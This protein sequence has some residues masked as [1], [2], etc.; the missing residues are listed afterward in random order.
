MTI[1][2]LLV[3][4]LETESEVTISLNYSFED[5]RK[6]WVVVPSGDDDRERQSYDLKRALKTVLEG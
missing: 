5:N 3:D 1:E 6:K 4:I 2:E